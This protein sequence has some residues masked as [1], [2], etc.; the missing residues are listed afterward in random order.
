MALL[1]LRATEHAARVAN[2]LGA[3]HERDD[4]TGEEQVHALN[5]HVTGDRFQSQSI[6]H[7]HIRSQSAMLEPSRVTA[8]V[9]RRPRKD[10]SFM[11][12]F[13]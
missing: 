2:A 3:A 11:M 4:D 6:K 7:E 12:H 13:K 10:K 9:A 1:P 5:L 8:R